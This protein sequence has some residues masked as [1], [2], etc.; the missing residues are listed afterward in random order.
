MDKISQKPH[1]YESNKRYQYKK[2]GKNKKDR[3]L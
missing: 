1:F 2:I 3:K